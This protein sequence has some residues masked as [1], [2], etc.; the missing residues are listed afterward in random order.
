MIEKVRY[1]QVDTYGSRSTSIRYVEAVVQLGMYGYAG[2]GDTVQDAKADLCR[3]IEGEIAWLQRCLDEVRASE[4]GEV[5]P[6][7]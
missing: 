5:E 6:A 1:Q 2:K 4:P 3:R 7:E